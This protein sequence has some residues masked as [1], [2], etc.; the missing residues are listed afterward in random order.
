MTISKEAT[1]VANTD[2]L[3]IVAPKPNKAP[4]PVGTHDPRFLD[5][6]ITR[7]IDGKNFEV[8][9]AFNYHTDVFPLFVVS[10]PAG[11]VTDFASIPKAFHNILPP[12]GKYGK[13]AVIH[14]YLYRT[15]GI[16]T[17]DEADQVFLEAMTALGVG[18]M[19]RNIMYQGVHR[20]GGSSYKGGL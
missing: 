7:Y 4:A 10:V 11:F 1:L 19:T 8:V 5:E 16:A 15:P 18:W 9:H 6:L 3:L 17:K 13:A 14:D 20:F 12:T 2:G